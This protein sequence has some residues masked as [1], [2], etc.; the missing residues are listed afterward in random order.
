MCPT[1]KEREREMSKKKK[2]IIEVGRR[3]AIAML[4]MMMAAG[5]AIIGFVISA[6]IPIS[7]EGNPLT[8]ALVLVGMLLLVFPI[9]IWRAK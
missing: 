4:L 7:Q 3:E 1:P 6:D 9:I 5:A 2:D 8:F